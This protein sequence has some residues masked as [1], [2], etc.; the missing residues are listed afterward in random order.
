MVE[1]DEVTVLDA[2]CLPVVAL[3][4]R[5]PFGL[6]PQGSEA[7]GEIRLRIQQLPDAGTHPRL[8]ATLEGTT[9]RL[10]Q[11]LEDPVQGSA[12][13]DV[14][15]RITGLLPG[16]YTVE[17]WRWRQTDRHVLGTQIGFTA[18]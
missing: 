4:N 7:A 8:V 14:D 10:E 12:S 15:L 2:S 11:R 3:P 13:C 16:T 1:V 9:V 5:P 6:L 18:R 17:V